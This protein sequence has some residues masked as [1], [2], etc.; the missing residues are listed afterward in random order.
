M[1]IP[2]RRKA[3][4]ISPVTS[5]PKGVSATLKRVDRVWNMQKP[6]WCLVVNTT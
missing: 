3:S 2:W 5:L 4:T 6:E 1:A